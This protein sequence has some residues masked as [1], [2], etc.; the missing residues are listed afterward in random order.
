MRVSHDFDPFI[1]PTADTGGEGHA[2]RDF[3]PWR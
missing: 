3:D 2:D 1:L